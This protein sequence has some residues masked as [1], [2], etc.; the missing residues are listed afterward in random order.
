[1]SN[2]KVDPA[3][4]PFPKSGLVKQYEP[5][6]RAEVSKFCGQFPWVRYD[7]VLI[8]A[9]KLADQAAKRFNPDLG[10]DFSTLLRHYLKKLYAMAGG[11]D[12][13]ESCQAGRLGAGSGSLTGPSIPRRCQR[14]ACRF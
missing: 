7:D 3:Y 10:N 14:Y 12:W 11:G 9:V 1:M 2:I 5:F 6:I 8:E 13:L 4:D